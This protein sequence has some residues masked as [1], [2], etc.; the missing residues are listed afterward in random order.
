M[1]ISQQDRMLLRE[2]AMRRQE[3]AESP[4][5][6]RLYDDWMAYAQKGARTRAMV[7]IEIETFEQDILPALL[8]CQGAEAREIEKRLM[9]TVANFSLFEDDTLI[10]PYYPVRDRLSFLP[11][12]LAPKVKHASGLGHHFIPQ[13]ADLSED[14]GI[15]GAS[16]YSADEAGAERERAE[17][18]ELLGDIM[19][20]RR[21]SDCMYACPTQDIVHIMNM[22]DM[23]IAMADDEENFHA[24]MRRLTDDYIAFFTTLAHGG[25]LRSAARG[26]H[27]N[28]GTYCFT[29]ELPDDQPNAALSDCWLFMDSQETAGVSP[30]MYREL[31]FP[32]YK[33]LFSCFGL[34][35]Y[36]CC[37]ATHA[38][39]DDCLSTLPNLRKVS[40]SPWCNE[41]MMGERLK[42]TDITYL[43]KPPATL[44]GVNETLDED[45][46]LSCMRKTA[47][48]AR[49]C[50]LEF[51]Q[52]DVYTV[53]HNPEKVKRYVQLI[54]QA[55]EENA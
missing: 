55:A 53:H 13:I 45:A 23:Y 9:R 7:R 30:A 50:R 38:I 14:M 3:L 35:S 28:Q 24:L 42:N 20:V 4:R 41:E 12:G 32:Y 34:A 21:I 36:G 6:K 31:V 1:N 54:R 26:Q 44:L 49:G 2:Q 52:R 15:L 22:D 51:I 39:W 17:M 37:E 43:R 16:V 10:P 48:A 11:F 27:L 8:L 47:R 46:V 33:E 18:E 25:H 5:N 40:I 19:P 29:T